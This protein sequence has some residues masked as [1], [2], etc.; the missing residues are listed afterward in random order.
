VGTPER[1]ILHVDMDAF[2]AAVEQRDQPVL[3]GKPVLVA[4]RG[5]R[6]VVTTASYEARPF[7]CRS[8][9]PTA[10]ALRL[11]PHAIVVP[12]RMQAYAEASK[13]VLAALNE[14][15]PDIQP[16]GLDE[17]FLEATGVM[18]LHRD[19]HALAAAIKH[20]VRQTTA[21]A[22]TV[23]IAHNKFL[24]KLASD[25]GKPDGLRHIRPADVDATLAPLPVRALFTI[26]PKAG[27]KLEQLGIRTVAD[28]RRA[29]QPT[30]LARFGDQARFWLDLAHGIDPRP[31]HPHAPARSIGRERTFSHD[32]S[33]PDQLRGWLLSEVEEA[34]R[35]LRAESL[36]AR[37]VIVKL[38][39]GDYTTSTR[40]FTLPQASDDTA[41]L[42]QTART[43]LDTWL[44][45]RRVPLRLV[46]V[47]LQDLS[48]TRQPGLFDELDTRPA[49]PPDAPTENA[50]APQRT[51]SSPPATINSGPAPARRARAD[52]ATDA[53]IARFGRG[54]IR[55]AASPPTSRPAI[56]PHSP[57]A[58]SP[59]HAPAAP[60]A[61][62]SPN[63]RA[64][65]TPPAPPPNGPRRRPAPPVD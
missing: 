25:L 65:S 47:S 44:K 21:L 16:L 31:L 41:T 5:P 6:G 23:G 64:R 57:N 26:G 51:P 22:C 58:P 24:A 45:G 34:A 19:A 48:N 39:T 27:A 52:Q 9:M 1:V 43:L 38:R 14:F 18:H 7:G 4:G 49:P 59:P 15:S 28:L 2:F 63:A 20:R 37:R 13:H 32:L 40:S 11:C 33:D 3:R 8:A 56:A 53:I 12:V 62:A 35:Q 50:S 29:D 46:G 17:A 60:G 30:L 42:W 54:A 36:L 10:Q 55:R 61:P